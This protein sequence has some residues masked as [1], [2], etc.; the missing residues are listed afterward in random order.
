[1]VY[2]STSRRRVFVGYH[3][4]VDQAYYDR[5]VFLFDEVYEI[6]ADRSL[7]REVD[8]DDPEYVM[9]RIRENYLKGSSVTVVLCGEET[10][11][12]KY[13]DWEIRAS[14]S[15]EMGLIGINL[16]TN[17]LTPDNK[18]IVPARLHDNL[19]SGYA[20]WQSRWQAL[21]DSPDL[22]S[23][24]VERALLRDKSLIDNSR[25]TM[26]RNLS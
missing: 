8:S 21:E 10:W 25:Q 12:R 13:V 20:V 4:D 17:P 2:K 23:E 15:Q 24:L 16:P 9:R 26:K 18:Y 11:K 5:F 19:L 6:V 22:L 3:H 7:D 14:L 1:M